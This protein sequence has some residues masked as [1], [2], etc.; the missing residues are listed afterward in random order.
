MASASQFDPPGKPE[1][2][3]SASPLGALLTVE[4]VGELLNVPSS[5][6]YERT[7]KRGIDRI[8]G[9]RLGKY[10]RFRESDVLAWLERQRVGERKNG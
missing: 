1:K 7:R 10:W 6:V 2:L 3:R 8:P 9:F 4:E 5:W